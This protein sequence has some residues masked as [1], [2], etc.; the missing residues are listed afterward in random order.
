MHFRDLVPDRLGVGISDLY[1]ALARLPTRASR[2]EIGR[3]V[4][5]KGSQELE[6]VF[7]SHQN[8]GPY[9]L[10]GVA[11][12]GL[13]ECVRA[14]QFAECL[15]SD[16]LQAV[17]QLMQTSHDGDRLYSYRTDGTSRRYSVRTDD[18]TLSQLANSNSDL[19]LQPGR[20]GC[21]TQ[22]IDRIVDIVSATK[23][24]VGAQLSGAGLGGCAMAM[25]HSGTKEVVVEQLEKAFGNHGSEIPIVYDCKPVAGAGLIQ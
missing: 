22:K 2:R 21:S 9:D 23:G 25:V 19:S 14:D 18:A 8:I 16:D 12:Y 10:R 20:Y 17:R 3:L 6:R 13:G 24:V 5:I 4:D 11:L 1:Q 15:K 7:E